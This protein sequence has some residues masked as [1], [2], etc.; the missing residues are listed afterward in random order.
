MF[1]PFDWFIHFIP[2]PNLV[3][4]KRLHTFGKINLWELHVLS[5]LMRLWIY[6]IFSQVFSVCVTLVRRKN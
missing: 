2:C 1:K 4:M 5:P 6:Y 3:I